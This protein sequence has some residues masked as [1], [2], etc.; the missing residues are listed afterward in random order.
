MSVFA[1]AIGEGSVVFP[2]VG[3]VAADGVAVS[4]FWVSAAG[5]FFVFSGI[6]VLS[7]PS[8]I[9][10]G[11]IVLLVQGIPAQQRLVA[12]DIYQTGVSSG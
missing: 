8:L 9:S 3:A 5:S 6:S 4:C 12:E 1:G 10:S 7:V 2:A 11:P